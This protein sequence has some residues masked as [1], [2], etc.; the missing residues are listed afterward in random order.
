[1]LSHQQ[2]EVVTGLRAVKIVANFSKIMTLENAFADTHQVL[3]DTTVTQLVNLLRCGHQ[4]LLTLI[5]VIHRRCLDW[6]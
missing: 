1:M 2:P 3:T 4:M 5:D 6:N